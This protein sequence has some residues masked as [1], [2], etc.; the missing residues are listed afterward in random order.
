MIETLYEPPVPVNTT[1]AALASLD[2]IIA[3]STARAQNAPPTYIGI[4]RFTGRMPAF[5]SGTRP[6]VAA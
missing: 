5:R 2:Y 4:Q 1:P 6:A 3:D